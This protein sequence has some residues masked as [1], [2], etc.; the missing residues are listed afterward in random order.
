[1]IFRHG[2]MLG[3]MIVEGKTAI[4]VREVLQELYRTTEQFCSKDLIY[5]CST[6]RFVYPCQSL[7]SSHAALPPQ[8]DSCMEHGARDPEGSGK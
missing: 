7:K 3:V 5:Q 1:M 2:K 6:R 4:G 8:A